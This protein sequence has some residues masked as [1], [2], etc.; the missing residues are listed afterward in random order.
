MSPGQHDA[1][2]RHEGRRH[3]GRRR[4]GGKPKAL[5]ARQTRHESARR[6]RRPAAAGAGPHRW[7]GIR[8][9]VAGS[10]LVTQTHLRGLWR[11]RRHRIALLSWIAATYLLLGLGWA[12]TGGTAGVLLGL[13]SFASL[14][15]GLCVAP[16]V[17]ATRLARDRDAGILPFLQ[18]SGVRPGGIT[19]GAWCSGVAAPALVLLATLP[20]LAAATWLDDS[21][22]APLAQSLAAQV[23]VIGAVAGLGVLCATWTRSR[24]AA[25]SLSY[26]GVALLTVGTLVGYALASSATTQT[27]RLP[28]RIAA[29]SAPTSPD[30][31]EAP[32]TTEETAP[33]GATTPP[34]PDADGCVVVMQDVVRYRPDRVWGFLA[35]NP[36]VVLADALPGAP[37]ADAGSGL[38]RTTPVQALG[39]TIR[40]TRV[41]PSDDIVENCVRRSAAG[42]A[43]ATTGAGSGDSGATEVGEPTGDPVWPIGVA[44]L[45]VLGAGALWLAPRSLRTPADRLG[46][47]PGRLRGLRRGATS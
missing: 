10:A 42:R 9:V 21:G 40:Q 14:S 30:A 41:A 47:A 5:R 6:V 32:A 28:V 39:A 13:V 1:G 35:L 17:A 34:T 44:A 26:V 18:V 27:V 37:T 23:A 36:Y 46:R 3:E 19:L 43:E 12:A 4:T 11:S 29:A 38:A 2:L 15:A 24:L 20:A 16:V 8:E 22:W 25:L 7:S 45:T 33:T 31:P